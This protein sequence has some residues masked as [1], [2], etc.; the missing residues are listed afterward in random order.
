[1][2]WFLNKERVGHLQ[3]GE[4]FAAGFDVAKIGEP[5]F[6]CTQ[7]AGKFRDL[8]QTGTAEVRQLALD[9]FHSVLVR[10]FIPHDGFVRLAGDF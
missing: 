9:F 7:H 5:F 2:N 1:M 4:N 6:V 10:F 3:G 8:I